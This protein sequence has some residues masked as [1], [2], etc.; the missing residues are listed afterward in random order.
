MFSV[1]LPVV[2]SRYFEAALKS[3]LNQDYRDF[4]LIV[5]DNDA[6]E[7]VQA[8]L[9]RNQDERMRSIRHEKQIPIIENWNKCLSYATRQYFVLFSD[10]DVMQPG[11]LE[12]VS[13]V[14]RANPDSKM[15]HTRV[16][17]FTGNNKLRGL[18]AIAPDVEDGINY[19]YETF[20]KGRSQLISDFVWQ[21][22]FFLAQSG[23]ES[24]E[25][26]WGSD[27]VT[28]YKM[29]IAAG[30]VHYIPEVMVWWRHSEINFTNKMSYRAQYSANLDFV[31]WMSGFIEKL[32]LQYGTTDQLKL[33][34][35]KLPLNFQARMGNC[36]QNLGM[37]RSFLAPIWFKLTN[38]NQTPTLSW[39]TVMR[40][41]VGVLHKKLTNVK[42]YRG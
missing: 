41:I 15:I 36:M 38:R 34:Q 39:M 18:S 42:H 22:E 37:S 31:R 1:V 11:Y 4:E 32:E 33:I 23:Y 7:E 5:V 3:V 9:G 12:A 6:D 35:K 17:M 21:R 19:V 24:L 20:C 25:G 2:K 10:D 14:I 16:R 27:E 28:T 8:I 13:Q 26:A 40:A 30:T 29:A